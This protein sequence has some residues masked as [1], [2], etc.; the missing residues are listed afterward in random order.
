MH[1][2]Q[3]RKKILTLALPIMGGMLSQSLLNLVDAALVGSLGETVLAGV[4]V[5]GYAIF[6]LSAIIAGFSSGVQ[7]Q[8]ARHQGARQYTIRA[9][10]LNAAILLALLITLPLSFFGWFNAGKLIALINPTLEVQQ[11]AKDYF[12][13]RVIALWPI[14]LTLCFRGYWHGIQKTGIYFQIIVFTHTLN[15]LLS[16]WLI[17]GGLGIAPLGASGAALGTS[18]SITIGSLIWSWLTWRNA[19]PSGFL[20]KLPNLNLIWKMLRLVAPNSLQQFL[21]AVSYAVLFW[22]LGQISTASVAVGHVLV[23]LSLLLILPSV[24]LGMTA[25]TLVGNSLG[26]NNPEE[27]Y[28]WGW[29]SVHLAMIILMVLSLPLLF[30]PEKILGLFLHQSYLVA[31]GKT[32]L[33][34]TGVMI[35]LDAAAIVFNQALQ[36]AGAQRLTMQVSLLMQW[37][38]FLPVAWL[39][40]IYFQWGLLGIWSVQLAYRIINSLVFI[41]IWQQRGWQKLDI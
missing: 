18:I 12:Q 36:G 26:E 2:M 41:K 9:S 10:P 5:G 27:A 25:M 11:V 37:L 38:I 22:F 40:G 15:I 3:R 21:F 30:F 31:L 4:G 8:V 33:M 32:P 29:D 14:A 39:F 28:R 19:C 17:H 34:L 20:L 6:M 16:I 23:H 1:Q 7:S 35:T 24:G 13:W